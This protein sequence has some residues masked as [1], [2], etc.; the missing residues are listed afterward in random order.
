MLRSVAVAILF[1]ILADSTLSARRLWQ[2]TSPKIASASRPVGSTEQLSPSEAYRYA[3]QPFLNARS[4]PNDLTDADV[5]ALGQAIIRAQQQCEALTKPSTDSSKSDATASQKS[6]VAF[7]GSKQDNIPVIP[8]KEYE[9]NLLALGRL[10]TFGQ[11]LEPAK[12]AL[13]EY[14]GLPGIEDAK[15]AYLLLTRVFVGLSNF[16]AAESTMESLVS[17]F[18]YDGDIHLAIDQTIDAAEPSDDKGVIERLN[19]LQLPYTLKALATGGVLKGK[20]NKINAAT[21]VADALRCADAMR[22][23]G[24]TK[25]AA[26]L[27]KKIKTL[28][29]APAIAQTAS[30]PEIDSAFMRYALVGQPAQHLYGTELRGELITKTGRTIPTTKLLTGKMTVLV[31]FSLAAPASEDVIT[32]VVTR[33]RQVHIEKPI[34]VIAITSYA[35]TNGEDKKSEVVLK[36][37]EGFAGALPTGVPLLLVPDATIKAFAIDA[38]PA[39]IVINSDGKILFLNLISGTNGSIYRLLRV[40]QPE[41]SSQRLLNQ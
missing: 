14:L 35:A 4:A 27:V 17:L 7:G 41:I 40:V 22:N 16:P 39:G 34:Q 12:N 23:E 37:L 2:Q 10:C 32:K 29:S 5:W 15:S 28:T 21:L 18:P 20:E 31:A 13:I 36:A 6:G 38:Y 24:K 8:S 26:A 3:M 25:D 30:K 19:S 1:F 9:N 33:L 11:D